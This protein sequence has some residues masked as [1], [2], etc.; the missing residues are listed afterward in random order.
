MRHFLI[1]AFAAAAALFAQEFR[2]TLAG[3]IADPS[4]AG[5]PKARIAAVQTETKSRFE[6]VSGPEGNY[7]IP[8]LAP[9]VYDALIDPRELPGARPAIRCRCAAD[10]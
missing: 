5:V 2:G 1:V 3:R 8:F 4:G 6:T 9:G 7:T 10:R